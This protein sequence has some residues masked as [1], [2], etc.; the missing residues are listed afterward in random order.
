MGEPAPEYLVAVVDAIGV[1]NGRVAANLAVLEE[2][3]FLLTN[4]VKLPITKEQAAALT[5]NFPDT[6]DFLSGP[7]E[8]LLLKRKSAYERFSKIRHDLDD[9]YASCDP[10]STLRDTAIFFPSPKRLERTMVIVKPGYT[11]EDMAQIL[12]TL[13]SNDFIILDKT[14]RLL[15]P[16]MTKVVF[17]LEDASEELD[18][19]T[20]EVSTAMVVEKVGAVDEWTL[21]MGPADPALARE[22]A[23]RSIRALLGKDLVRNAVYGSISDEKGE[24]DISLRFPGPLPLERTLAIVKPDVVQNGYL[25][26]ILE[27]IKVN[28]FAIVASEMLHLSPERAEQLCSE[29][30]QSASFASTVRYMSSGP[31]MALVLSKPGAVSAWRKLVGPADVAN[32]VASKPLSLRARFG[33][34]TVVNGFHCSV[35]AEKA[36]KEIDLYFPQLSVEKI[37]SLLEVEEIMNDKPEPRPHVTSTKSLNEVLVDGLTQLCRIKPVGMDAVTWLGE[38]LLRNNPN[39]PVVEEP[40]VVVEEPTVRDAVEA[41]APEAASSIIWAVG[42]PG[43]GRDEHCNYIVKNFGYEFIDVQTMISAAESSGNEY[44]ELIKETKRAGKPIP[45]HITT[46]LIKQAILGT[47]GTSKF[48]VN[49]F[50]QNLDEAFDFESRVGAV[51]MLL[52]FDCSQKTRTTRLGGQDKEAELQAFQEEVFPVVEHYSAFSKTAKISTDGSEAQI[53]SRVQRLFR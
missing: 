15:T 44:G 30:K 35:D 40:A 51:D 17:G 12:D 47:K 5:S 23:P 18:Y 25:N 13:E 7:V 42:G 36:R 48:V 9:V 34:D 46:A 1:R 45:T 39:K 28:G 31:C 16:D 41:A 29:E 14:S 21:L 32:A 49:G 19:L 11:P 24:N 38:W 50:P 53:T 33:T 3:G 27:L 10:W 37:P 6:R 52:Y 20:R 4:R 2:E 8:A 22:I 26:D 43:S